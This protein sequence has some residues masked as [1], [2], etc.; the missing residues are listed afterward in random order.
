MEPPAARVKPKRPLAFFLHSLI[1]L[2]VSV[3]LAFVCLTGSIAAVSHELEWLVMPQVRAVSD[4]RTD[5]WAGM[6]GAVHRAY[7]EGFISGLGAYDRADSHYFVRVA[8]VSFPDGRSLEAFVDPARL[9]VTGARSGVS[10]HSLMRAVHYYLLLPTE[11][12]FYLV[13]SL[14]FVL[15]AALTTGLITYKK[16]WRGFL[17]PPRLARGLRTAAGD[18]HRLIGLWSLWFVAVIALTGVWYFYER[19]APSMETAQPTATPIVA[20]AAPEADAVA[21]WIGTA[22]RAMP[23]LSITHIAMPYGPGDPVV[24]QGRWRSVLVRERT[25]AVFIDPADG[26]LL[27]VRSGDRMGPGERWANTA[28]PLHFGNFAGLAGKLVWV[29]FGL[30]LSAMAISGAVIFVQRMGRAKQAAGPGL[31]RALDYLGAW[32]WPSL[33]LLAAPIWAF[34]TWSAAP[35]PLQPRGEVVLG[36]DRLAVHTRR[37]EDGG[38]LLRLTP[39][40]SRTGVVR[41]IEVGAAEADGRL[42]WRPAR[43]QTG[44]AVVDLACADLCDAITVRLRG[45]SG[46]AAELAMNR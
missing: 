27:G 8:E 6:W 30:A 29:V 34:P 36:G 18:L 17:R 15:V 24:I 44:A 20:M 10:F 19:F 5:D 38:M 12:P 33:V 43:Y 35:P 13:T 31:L 11:A 40:T 3:L 23:G 4:G 22:R 7:P 2:K 16:F 41:T 14:S 25:D 32:K 21:G 1:G 26:R 42:T 45:E 28:D 46:A 37:L 9:T 39:V